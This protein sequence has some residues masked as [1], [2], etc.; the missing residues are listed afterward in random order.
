MNKT[1]AGQSGQT[2]DAIEFFAAS[3]ARQGESLRVKKRRAGVSHKPLLCQGGKLP[4]F[5]FLS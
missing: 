2:R 5:A 3:G 4:D 1:I